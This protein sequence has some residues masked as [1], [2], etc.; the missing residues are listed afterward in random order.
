MRVQPCSMQEMMKRGSQRIPGHCS[1]F[2]FTTLAAVFGRNGVMSHDV[3]CTLR[4]CR[5]PF[6]VQH[7]PPC[8][9]DLVTEKLEGAFTATMR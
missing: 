8:I 9:G 4:M 5:K 3:T 1:L 7:V 2:D 6:H